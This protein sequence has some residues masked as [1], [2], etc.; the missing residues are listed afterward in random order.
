VRALAAAAADVRRKFGA[1]D[2]P[3]GQVHR[4]RIAGKDLPVGG[5]SGDI[6]CF[7]VLWYKDEQDGTRT[8]TGGDGWILAVE[9]GETPQAWS[10]LAYGNSTLAESPLVGDQAEQFAQ[11]ELKPVLFRAAD[12]DAAAVR[13]YRPE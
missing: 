9:F 10:V 5:C 11:G 3:W 7:R 12:I 1:L 2:V 13:R 6:G 4:I 8:V